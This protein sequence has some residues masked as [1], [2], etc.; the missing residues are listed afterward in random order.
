MILE[1]MFPRMKLSNTAFF[2][3]Y[4]PLLL[5]I[6]HFSSF[7]YLS[8]NEEMGFAVKLRGKQEKPYKQI[9]WVEG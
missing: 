9:V 4:I 2:M 8:I 5:F 7:C 1:I 3:V 6:L